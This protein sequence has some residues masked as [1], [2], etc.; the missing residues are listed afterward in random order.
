[1]IS[2]NLGYVVLTPPIIVF[3]IWYTGYIDY[4]SLG[5]FMIV[6]IMNL[7]FL[8]KPNLSLGEFFNLVFWPFMLFYRYWYEP[9]FYYFWDSITIC[10][11][12][13]SFVWWVQHQLARRA[14]V[15]QLRRHRM[16]MNQLRVD[17]GIEPLAV[18]ESV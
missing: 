9:T 14:N 12:G 3:K 18:E 13:I 17:H 10:M 5:V 15:E 11:L 16:I 2:F 7:G 8:V 4:Y 1:M 6:W